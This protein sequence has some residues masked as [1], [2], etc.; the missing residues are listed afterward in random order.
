[1]S[2]QRARTDE[3]REERRRTILETTA[4]M[5]TEMTVSEI[6]LNELSRRVGLAKSNVLR[7]F[8]SREAIL[9]ELLD[10]RTIEWAAEVQETVAG[11]DGDSRGGDNGTVAERTERF[12]ATIAETLQAQPVTCDLI[13]AQSVVL[14]RNV[15]TD[16]AVDHKHRTLELSR[17]LGGTVTQLFPELTDQDALEFTAV[18]VLTV[19]SAWPSCTPNERVSA[20]YDADPDLAPL[21]MD[22]TTIVTRALS[23]CLRGLL[24]EHGSF[25][26]GTQRL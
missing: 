26:R 9:L 21:H 23:L 2:F 22:F 25:N 6:S 5:L 19:A 4:A 1:M 14:E 7:Y 16:V 12:A 11:S 15:S 3:Q 10:A 17:Q 24:A 8:E 13:S 18:L 20:A